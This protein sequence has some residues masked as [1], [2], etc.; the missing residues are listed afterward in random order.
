MVNF[1]YFEATYR[2]LRMRFSLQPE[3][4]SRLQEYRKGAPFEVRKYCILSCRLESWDAPTGRALETCQK[5]TS[6]SKRPLRLPKLSTGTP[7]CAKLHFLL[8]NARSAF[9]SRF[10]SFRN[11]NNRNNRNDRNN[12]NSLLR[13]AERHCRHC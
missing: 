8:R 4:D 9:K 6:T 5:W 2:K 1:G 13:V 7:K 12:I 3:R 11:R 10:A